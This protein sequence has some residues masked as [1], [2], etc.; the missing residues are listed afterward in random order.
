MRF[1]FVRKSPHWIR[2]SHIFFHGLALLLDMTHLLCGNSAGWV[3]K[4]ILNQ[5]CYLPTI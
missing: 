1:S 4:S 2:F 3:A 5:H